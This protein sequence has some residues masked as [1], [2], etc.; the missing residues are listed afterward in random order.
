[1]SARKKYYTVWEGKEPGVY[2]SW[3]ECKEQTQS[4]PGAKYKSFPTLESAQEAFAAGPPQDYYKTT[5]VKNILQNPPTDRQDTVLPL[6][7]EVIAKAIAVDA[8][9]SK[10]P[11][12]ME[13]HGID[14][15]TGA[16]NFHFGPIQGT[17]NIGEFL[18]IV[19]CLALLDKTG[20]TETVV[21]SDSRNALLWVKKQHCAT[22]LPLTDDTKN[23]LEIIARATK[24]LQTHQIKNRL[25]KWETSKW[26][27]IPADFGRK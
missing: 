14:L 21:Y 16:E 1:M 8:A 4:R 22:K 10:N 6:P 2:S 18:A 15:R 9:C 25:I 7:K 23:V 11:G 27:E 3:D 26:G 5:Q 17:N 12:P 20:D 13:Y 19:H 24:W